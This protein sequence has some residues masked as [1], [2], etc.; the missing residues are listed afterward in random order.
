MNDTTDTPQPIQLTEYER[1]SLQLLQSI[2]DRLKMM[3]EA[4]EYF[5]RQHKATQALMNALNRNFPR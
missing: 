5:H 2:D 3:G 4:T 1:L